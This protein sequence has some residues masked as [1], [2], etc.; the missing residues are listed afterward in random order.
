MSLCQNSILWN[1]SSLKLEHSWFFI[2]TTF[3]TVDT[4]WRHQVYEQD[5]KIDVATEKKKLDTVFH[6]TR[7]YSRLSKP[8]WVTSLFLPHT[9]S[10]CVRSYRIC[11]ITTITAV[12][13]K[14]DDILLSFT[15]AGFSQLRQ[16]N[17]RETFWIYILKGRL[18]NLEVE[19]KI[20]IFLCFWFFPLVLLVKQY[21]SSLFLLAVMVDLF[22]AFLNAECFHCFERMTP[23]GC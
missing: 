1:T 23:G 14:S 12:L 5:K 7:G 4:N 3:Y 6:M 8:V 20:L 17:Q 18:I 13:W 10:K 15:K 2:L 19:K 22:Y 9:Y 16:L 21:I 11:N